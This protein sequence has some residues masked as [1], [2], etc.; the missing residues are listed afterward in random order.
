MVYNPFLPFP[1]PFKEIIDKGHAAFQ[2]SLFLAYVP[3]LQAMDQYQEATIIIAMMI[4]VTA[5]DSITSIPPNSGMVNTTL[6][7]SSSISDSTK[8]FILNNPFLFLFAFAYYSH[9]I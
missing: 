2:G 6:Q 9:L 1:K 3:H 5:T 7:L 8:P 4:H